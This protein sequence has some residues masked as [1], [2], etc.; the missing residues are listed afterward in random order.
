MLLV[1]IGL[2]VAHGGAGQEIDFPDVGR[3]VIAET[4]DAGIDD[5]GM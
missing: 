1:S 5:F 4:A 3:A 2:A